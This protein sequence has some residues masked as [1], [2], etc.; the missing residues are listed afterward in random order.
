MSLITS[1]QDLTA[2]I[3]QNFTRINTIL[4]KKIDAPSSASNG[5]VLTYNGSTWTAATPSGGGASVAV[6]D[7]APANPTDGMLWIDTD[8]TT[9]EGTIAN[10]INLSY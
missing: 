9:I 7:T 6:S 5:Q 2:V 10:G 3:K 4:T 8:D 1:F